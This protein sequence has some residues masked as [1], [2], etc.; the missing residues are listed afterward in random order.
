MLAP[1]RRVST[2]WCCLSLIIHPPI[3]IVHQCLSRYHTTYESIFRSAWLA[4]MASNFSPDC[5]EY[6]RQI[7]L[8]LVQH[9]LQALNL[10][11]VLRPLTV[12]RDPGVDVRLS[13]SSC[14]RSAS[15]ARYRSSALPSIEV[16]SLVCSSSASDMLPVC[17]RCRQIKHQIGNSLSTSDRCTFSRNKQS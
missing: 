6:C 9:S 7:T 10:G 5:L 2:S 16:R 15:I 17:R 14:S 4:C 11:T 12:K 8:R 1:A 13:F 3:A